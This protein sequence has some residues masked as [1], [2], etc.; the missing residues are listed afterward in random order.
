MAVLLDTG[1]FFALYDTKDSNHDNSVGLVGHAL[2]GRWGGVFVSNYVSLETTLLLGSKM[3]PALARVFLHFVEKSGMTEILVDDEIIGQAKEVFR[4]DAALSL[5][6][7][8]S[9]VLARTLGIRYI[10]TYD[11]R[12]FRSYSDDIIGPSYWD[13][14]DGDERKR[15]KAIVSPTGTGG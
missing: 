5:T 15:L 14:L 9:V 7:S 11:Q 13:S 6:D 4:A 12:S 1:V 2:M 8:V 3:G 10:G